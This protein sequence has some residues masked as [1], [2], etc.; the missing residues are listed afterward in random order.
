MASVP[1]SCKNMLLKHS[2][3]QENQK[4][5]QMEL[6]AYKQQWKAKNSPANGPETC[7]NTLWGHLKF[8]YC[9]L[10]STT[11]SPRRHVTCPNKFAQPTPGADRWVL[12]LCWHS[13][14]TMERPNVRNMIN[15]CHG[16]TDETL[17]PAMLYMACWK[18]WTIMDHRNKWCPLA[19]S[20][21]IHWF[22]RH[23]TD[24]TRG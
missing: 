10:Q 24:D 16:K 13:R 15:T 22:S 12:G 23:V 8:T 19:S 20:T 11:R 9:H 6:A 4:Q 1:L 21:S 14:S 2:S 17:P 5:C 3:T 7:Q 18:P